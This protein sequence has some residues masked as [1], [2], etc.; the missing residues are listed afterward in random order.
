MVAFLVDDVMVGENIFAFLKARNVDVGVGEP[1]KKDI[2]FEV[3][4]T[5]K[6]FPAVPMDP[7]ER[8]GVMVRGGGGLRKGRVGVGGGRRVCELV[9]CLWTV[10]LGERVEGVEEQRVKGVDGNTSSAGG[11]CVGKLG[12]CAGVDVDGHGV[13]VD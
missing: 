11:R 5:T 13:R 6:A 8:G 12:S 1:F 4:F 7:S 9:G 10:R 3:V 2:E